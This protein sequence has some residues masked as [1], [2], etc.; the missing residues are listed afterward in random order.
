[1]HQ[2]SPNWPTIMLAFSSS[3]FISLLHLSFSRKNTLINIFLLG[4]LVKNINADQVRKRDEFHASD[5]FFDLKLE[6][7]LGCT[8]LLTSLMIMCIQYSSWVWRWHLDHI[9]S[10]NS[11]RSR[12]Q[13]FGACLRSW[14]VSTMFR[15]IWCT[16]CNFSR[17][18]LLTINRWRRTDKIWSSRVIDL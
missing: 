15:L 9:S 5:L 2:L 8:T 10:G 1:M 7:P 3:Q 17:R 12:S 6:T 18:V 11:Y 16:F 14:P 4:H 13:T